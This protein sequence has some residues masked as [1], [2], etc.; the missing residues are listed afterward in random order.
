MG[1]RILNDALRTMVNAERR[2]M[3]TALLQPIS[4][5]M[6]SFLNIMKHRGYI[7]K[8]EVMDPH[9]VGKI[10]VE[11]HGRIKD[12]KALTYRQDIRAK[13]IEQYRIRMLPTRQW[14][15]VV[16]TTPNGV[17]D[18]EEA[19]RQNVGGQVLGSM[20]ILGRSEDVVSVVGGFVGPEG[21]WGSK[22]SSWSNFLARSR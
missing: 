18:H 8:F 2:G 9:R 11:L 17:L 13:E 10:N 4:G 12:C 22:A 21:K 6:V 20:A 3:A 14:G 5:V 1:R 19:I 16:I 15:Y 7:K